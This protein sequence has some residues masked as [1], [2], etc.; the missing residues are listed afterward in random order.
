MPTL[1][2]GGPLDGQFI[3]VDPNR[4]QVE[5]AVSQPFQYDEHDD[6]PRTF[7]DIFYYRREKL[8]CPSS[9]YDIFVP[10]SFTCENVIESL[11]QG[12]HQHA[13]SNS[14]H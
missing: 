3:E 6:K 11:I 10:R 5:V 12:Y 9:E 2:M 4:R 7:T 8:A 14:G 1:F 13:S